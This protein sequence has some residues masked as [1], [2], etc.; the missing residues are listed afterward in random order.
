MIIFGIT[1][2][3]IALYLFYP[4][5]LMISAGKGYDPVEKVEI[6]GVSLVLLSYNGKKYLDEKIGFL[7]KELSF[8]KN[9]ELIIVDDHSHD[10]T[11]ELLEQYNGDPHI[12]IISKSRHM[13]IPDSMNSAINVAKYDYV[14]F[15]DQ[16]QRLSG[17]ILQ[18]ITEPLKYRD[19]AAVSGCISDTD[20]ENNCSL[21]RRH[22]NF[23]KMK[24]S[25]QG[26]LI[27]V[28]GPF[29]AIKKDCF[30]TIPDHIILDDLY[31]SLRILK[32]KKIVLHENCCI[33]DENNV[34]L[35][36]Y[37]RA[38]RY[39]SGLMQL[40]GEKSLISGLSLKHKVMLFWHKYLRL[41]IPVFMALSYFTA[42]AMTQKGIGFQVLFIAMTLLALV[43]I[44]PFHIRGLGSVKNLV[45]IMIFYFIALV[46]VLL[47]KILSYKISD[48]DNNYI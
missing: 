7:L 42:G 15:C 25:R 47:S 32:D 31:L 35:Y 24:E 20:C 38:R 48:M 26:S 17:N 27:G 41:L 3:L 45:R 10:D 22:E 1:L 46:D 33:T 34:S 37:S 6:E 44:L 29:Y 36:N 2:F 18:H 11:M 13:G 16:R 30:H 19:T 23:L 9:F 39:L 28:Y 8:F 12:R 4:L 40:P 5:W 43:S 14:V 21:T